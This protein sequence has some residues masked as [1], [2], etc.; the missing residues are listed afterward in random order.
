MKT[1]IFLGILILVGYLGGLCTDYVIDVA[2]G[3]DIPFI[4]DVGIGVVTGEIIV[5][6]AL[7]CCIVEACDVETPFFNRLEPTT[8]P[9]R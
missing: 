7:I 1:V 6:V 2:F 9:V 8:Q 4:A 5:P 3:K